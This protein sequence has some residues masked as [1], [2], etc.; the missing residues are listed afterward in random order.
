MRKSNL[1]LLF[2]DWDESAT[3]V[4]VIYAFPKRIIGRV[5]TQRI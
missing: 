4:L 2:K 5:L 1:E 3:K